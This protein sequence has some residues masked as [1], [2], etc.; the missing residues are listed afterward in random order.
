MT[1]EQETTGGDRSLER[2]ME[3]MYG[4]L[5]ALADRQ[6]RSARQEAAL[7]PTELVHECYLKLSQAVDSAGI[8]RVGFIALAARVIRNTLVDQA[9]TRGA[10]KRGGGLSRITLHE[11]A[12]VS[13]A[14][15]VDLLDLDGALTRL[16]E[17]DER[18]ARIVE[19][20][21]FGGLTADEVAAVMGVSRRTITEEWGMARVWLKRELSR[22]LSQGG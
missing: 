14:Q 2:L 12:I 22:G 13:D 7:D 18:Q 17:L 16:G 1:A 5:R 21:F 20:R 11:E 8:D 3:S 15:S 6:L 19:L 4:S 9:R 10:V